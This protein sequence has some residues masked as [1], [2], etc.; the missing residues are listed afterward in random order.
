M[1]VTLFFQETVGTVTVATGT[2]VVCL[3]T[4]LVEMV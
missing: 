1:T 4:V 3:E 2:F